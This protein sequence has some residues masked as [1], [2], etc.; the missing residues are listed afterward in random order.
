YALGKDA[1]SLVFHPSLAPTADEIHSLVAAIL[2]RVRILLK[3]RGIIGETNGEPKNPTAERGVADQMAAPG[4]FADLD[5]EG[6]IIPS[7]SP[8]TQRKVASSASET[9]GFSLDASVRIPAADLG[10]RERLC[11]YG[12][13]H[14][15]A[16]ERLSETADGAIA[17]R[18][19]KP[20]YGKRFLVMTPI[21]FLRRL[22]FLVPPP[23][24]PLIRYHGVL[25]PNSRLR[26]LVVRVNTGPKARPEQPELCA[27]P[28][29]TSPAASASAYE[30][31]HASVTA[32][33]SAAISACASP[34]AAI[35]SLSALASTF[36]AATA[37]RLSHF[38]WATLLKRI[39]DIDALSCPHCDSRLDFIAVITEPEPIRDILAHLGLPSVPPVFA[40]ARDPTWSDASHPSASYL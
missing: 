27:E 7:P 13:R 15:F 14:P 18:M 36:L 25:A 28:T 29:S 10:G 35:A 31:E 16:L 19:K 39:Y 33:A 24:Y 3:R 4:F 8:R 37:S 40:R 17:Y 23:F 1:E 32:T 38:E 2:R 30:T 11:R 21:A 12:A 26:R 6:G 20:R 22:A 34:P 9:C 5:D